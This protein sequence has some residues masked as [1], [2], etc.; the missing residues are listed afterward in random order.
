MYLQRI[1]NNSSADAPAATDDDGEDFC[2]VDTLKKAKRE[3]ITQKFSTSKPYRCI[4]LG[5]AHQVSIIHSHVNRKIS[6]RGDKQ[7]HR[8][9]QFCRCDFSL[10]ASAT[11]VW[12]Q[13]LV[14]ADRLRG[15][16]FQGR[17]ISLKRA[18]HLQAVALARSALTQVRK[19]NLEKLI[20]APTLDLASCGYPL[21]WGQ[22][23][24]WMW[25]WVIQVVA[26]V[27]VGCG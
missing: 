10:A 2:R 1:F 16:G 26:G 18:W 8:R 25:V 4:P 15:G 12:R 3:K 24:V 22:R 5:R 27:G 20:A 13:P 6:R 9:Q 21:L 17:R 19:T 23:R 7:G 14:S 11:V